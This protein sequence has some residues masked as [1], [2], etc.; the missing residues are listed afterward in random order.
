M[1]ETS[2]GEKIES[3]LDSSDSAGVPPAGSE[4]PVPE[5]IGKVRLESLIA[6]GGMGAV[7]RGRHEALDISVAVKI[8]P[9]EL[10]DN[11]EY[12][13]CL[14][15]EARAAAKV[16]HPNIVRVYD[17][18]EENG[19]FYIVMELVDGL[20]CETI[21]EQRGWLLKLEATGTCP[22]VAKALDEISRHGMV[23]RDI[24]PSN[25]LIA[26]DGA[27]KLTDLGLAMGARLDRTDA[28]GTI[29]SFVTP[30]YM[31]P[32]MGIYGAPVDQ[33]SD[34]YCLGATFYHLLTG[35]F[36][37]PEAPPKELMRMHAETPPR[38]VTDLAPDV[39]QRCAQVVEQMLA[40]NPAARFQ[41]A[42]ELLVALADIDGIAPDAMSGG[43]AHPEA[44]T[45]KDLYKAFENTCKCFERNASELLAM[46]VSI[47]LATSLAIALALALTKWIMDWPDLIANIIVIFVASAAA[48][49]L[50]MGLYMSVMMLMRAP[51][52][53][54]E[55]TSLF[56][57]FD[58]FTA[59]F[60]IVLI[61][62]I[63]NL[64][65]LHVL[66]GP[67]LFLGAV[68]SISAKA[69][70]NFAF[71][72][73]ATKQAQLK[74]TPEKTL[75]LMTEDYVGAFVVGFTMWIFEYSLSIKLHPVFYLVI[76]SGLLPF[77]ACLVFNLRNGR[78]SQVV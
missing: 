31:A 5:C 61:P 16:N 71:Y 1:K 63:I 14:L 10:A 51:P 54:W 39:S 8:L 58:L 6:S 75:R 32:E 43:L 57:G 25:I 66:K 67:F 70:M 30:E 9:K 21:L 29:Y 50:I 46:G 42:S 40:K 12:A 24:N 11:S 53:K 15:R 27:V 34:I 55:F 59:A 49:P 7:Y 68:T 20:S 60:C 72:L 18:G 19:L 41:S 35:E 73:M 26:K 64:A 28:D 78:G 52:K 45:L 76:L 33:R 22:H 44:R 3:T 48:G 4:T 74:T 13:Q 23:H 37:F 36:M 2:Q 65:A 56:K 69:F 47:A 38:P 62:E 17:C 77:I